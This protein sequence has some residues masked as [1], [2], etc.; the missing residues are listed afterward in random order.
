MTKDKKVVKDF[1]ELREI[2]GMAN[3]GD[4]NTTGQN[5][6]EQ[7]ERHWLTREEYDNLLD[8][9]Q[10]QGHNP[11]PFDFVFFQ[12]SPQTYTT[13]ELGNYGSLKSG[14]IDVQ[15]KALTPVHIVGGQDPVPNMAGK[16]IQKSYFYMQ[17]GT[18]CIPGSS[19]RGML[20]TFIEAVT[21]G[22]V[23]Q[24]NEE[25]TR[26]EGNKRV[27]HIEFKSWEEQGHKHRCL[28]SP[29]GVNFTAKPAI[30]DAYKPAPGDM[31][32][33]ASFLF[34]YV[35]ESTES[36]RA[37]RVIIE[38]AYV[39][40]GDLR[41]YRMVD[42]EAEAIMG[43]PRPRANWWYM[44]PRE[45]WDRSVQGG[46]RQVAHIVGDHF[47]GRKFYY[48]QEPEDCINFYLDYQ[49]WWP[50]LDM[51]SF[52]EDQFQE[53]YKIAD[54]CSA[55]RAEGIQMN[56]GDTLDTLNA[57][58]LR[59]SLY[60]EME[61]S[62]NQLPHQDRLKKLKRSYDK[63]VRKHMHNNL[64]KLNRCLIELAFPG[65]CPKA[66]YWY[67][68]SCLDRDR[69]ASFRIYLNRVPEKLLKLLCTCLCMPSTSSMRHKLGYGKAFGYGSVE[70]EITSAM[71]RTEKQADFPDPLSPVSPVGLVKGWTDDEVKEF[72]DEPSL[73]QLARIL[74]Y[75]PQD[76]IIFTYPPY[77]AQNFQQVIQARDF[78]RKVRSLSLSSPTN[79]VDEHTA[80]TVARELWDIKHPVHFLL[81]Q[82]RAGGYNQ[83]KTRSP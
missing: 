54:L 62:I 21:N 66:T 43:G 42:V 82:A 47:W 31:I 15:L 60:S 52:K 12:Q 5:T 64:I 24:A 63:S 35:D 69:T 10:E 34:G 18:P 71:L 13:E 51:H 4:M 80:L 14:Y 9:E 25:Y 57:L 74:T 68:M 3:P 36:S 55:I 79:P 38:D 32:D 2:M 50:E 30:P 17:D 83:I 72:I 65:Q 6:D 49:K 29:A 28:N 75:A 22:W 23:S 81:Y 48:H 45:V 56:N 27:R 59:E 20:R 33:T 70:F 8:N 67:N 58:L 46:R 61:N 7:T 1:A 19:I 77:S 41:D 37:G 16:K 73:R 78:N 40:S 26:D 76:D 53:P 11:N 44:R 39:N